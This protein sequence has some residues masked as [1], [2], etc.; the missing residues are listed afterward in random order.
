MLRRFTF[1]AI[2]G[3]APLVVNSCGSDG[4]PMIERDAGVYAAVIRAL[5]DEPP[6]PW[7][8]RVDIDDQ[9][10]RVVFAGPL[11]EEIAISLEVQ[12]AVVEALEDLATIRFVDQRTEAIDDDDDE[13][14]VLEGGMLVLLGTV[15]AGRSPAVETER[16]VALD[17]ATQYVVTAEQSDGEWMVVN[18]EQ[19]RTS[20]D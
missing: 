8:D 5:A 18:L 14:P 11:D 15:P 7:R 9:R 1:L 16:Y 12:A 17:A 10:E 6:D 2:A 13:Q 20:A 3:L 4:S 19:A